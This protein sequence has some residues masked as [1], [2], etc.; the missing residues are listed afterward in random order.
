MEY[1]PQYDA[2]H[3]VLIGAVALASLPLSI[4]VR[5]LIPHAKGTDQR[6]LVWAKVALF[7]LFLGAT[8]L[9]LQDILLVFIYYDVLDNHRSLKDYYQTTD[10]LGNWG[11]FFA[12]WCFPFVFVSLLDIGL[13]ILH[14]CNRWKKIRPILQ[15]LAYFLVLVEMVFTLTTLIKYEVFA[16]AYYQKD[17]RPGTKVPSQDELAPFQ[18]LMLA[19]N[20]LLCIAHVGAMVI[21][22]FAMV[23]GRELRQHYQVS[24]AQDDTYFML[25]LI[26]QA[27]VMLVGAN[28]FSFARIPWA[29]AVDA[30]WRIPGRGN[31]IP[32]QYYLTDAILTFWGLVVC[33]LLVFM[34]GAKKVGWLRPTLGRFVAI[35]DYEGR[36]GQSMIMTRQERGLEYQPVNSHYNGDIA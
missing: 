26:S 25:T 7:F 24:S 3:C 8:L 35:D 1:V 5:R 21:S 20:I 34:I 29:L 19:F 15:W 23:L 32:S 14:C 2:A 22:T 11:W 17:G 10:R 33:L 13:G 16:T 9:T 31:L 36:D 18:H 27:A 4:A 30:T 12:E 6:G 28:I